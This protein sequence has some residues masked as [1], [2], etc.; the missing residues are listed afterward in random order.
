MSNKPQPFGA[1]ATKIGYT[2]NAGI[3]A[4]KINPINKE[5]KPLRNRERF[6]FSLRERAGVRGN[7]VAWERVSKNDLKN[8]FKPGLGKRPGLERRSSCSSS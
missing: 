7:E 3:T 1:N 5:W 8:G 4:S 2:G 6:S